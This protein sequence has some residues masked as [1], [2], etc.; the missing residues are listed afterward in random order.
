MRRTKCKEK[1]GK[2]SAIIGSGP[3]GM[4]AA[5]FLSLFGHDVT[6]YEAQPEAG[7]M[8]R[9]GIPDYRLP[10]EV[11]DREIGDILALG[12]NL[13]TN[14]RVGKDV[15]LQE[16]MKESDACL[17]TT[18]AWNEKHLKIPGSELAV[19]G[20]D[21]LKDAKF[22]K[23]KKPGEKVLILGG[24]GVA[25]DY[26]GTAM[27]LGAEVHIAC[28]EPRAKMVAPEEDVVQAEKEGV[29]IHPSKTFQRIVSEKGR[30]KGVECMDV[31][32]FRFG[33]AGRLEVETKPG[34][35]HILPADTVIFAV[36]EEPD[37]GFLTGAGNFGITPRGT[38]EVD[39]RT[40]ETSVRGVFAAGDAV[41]G[42][43][44]IADAIGTGRAAA[45]SI[46]CF[47]QGKNIEEIE[48]ISFDETGEIIVEEYRPGAKERI[49]AHVVRYDEILNPDYYKKQDRVSGKQL[50]P[51]TARKSFQEINK[52]YDR[53]EAVREA[54]RCFHCGHCAACGTCVEI[55]PLDVLAMGQ[56]GPEVAYPKEC[57]HCGGCRVNCPCGAVYYE[58]PLSML[59]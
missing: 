54:N 17:V 40:F 46:D 39:S 27:R 52:G 13:R 16:I 31:Q 59:V 35:E 4:T 32:S 2:K 53:E 12:V 38:L 19:S 28:L 36:G 45:L 24:G 58:F 21:L 26:A 29:V 10:K 5:Y 34:S 7:G 3:A 43:S 11:V 49:P 48:S 14:T 15:S 44:S 20:F 57:W 9:I 51:E 42:P 30:V 33:P 22:G 41:K 56:N 55:C 23:A 47:L 50:P 37:L 6:V 18:G 1:T 25:F 8:P